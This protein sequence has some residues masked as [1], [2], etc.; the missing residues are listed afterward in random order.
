MGRALASNALDSGFPVGVY[1]IAAERVEGLMQAGAQ[2]F[3][4][5]KAAG[6]WADVVEVVVVDD[7]QV[8]EVV[9]GER[10]ILAGARPGKKGSPK[11]Q[12]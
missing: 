12:L 1:D 2:R 3:D 9:L 5:P 6:E 8:E 7:A 4:S 11:G 10:G